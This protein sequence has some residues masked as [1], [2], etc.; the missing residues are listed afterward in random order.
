MYC[1]SFFICLIYFYCRWGEGML[2][3][4]LVSNLTCKYFSLYL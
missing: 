3:Q 2:K 1:S 4:I